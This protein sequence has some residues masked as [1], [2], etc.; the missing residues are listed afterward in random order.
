MSIS[1][2]G[3]ATA[4]IRMSIGLD[5]GP[6]F[7]HNAVWASS[8]R[9][10]AAADATLPSFAPLARAGTVRHCITSL[11]TPASMKSPQ[12]WCEPSSLTQCQPRRR[13]PNAV[14]VLLAYLIG[15]PHRRQG[16][17]L[18]PLLAFFFLCPIARRGEQTVNLP[19]FTAFSIKSP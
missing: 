1:S 10:R 8:P 5:V 11:F 3:R 9:A 12:R 15:L 16:R 19:A 4:G 14:H 2:P 18:S 17:T 13:C 6:L 7:E